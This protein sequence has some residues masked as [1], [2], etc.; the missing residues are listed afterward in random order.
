MPPQVLEAVLH[1]DSAKL[2]T[3]TGVD[4]GEQ[5]YVVVRLDA[6]LSRDTKAE[7]NARLQAQYAQAWGGA[8]T[9]AYLDALKIRHKAETRAPA[10]SEPA[11]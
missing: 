5:G 10:A 8:E 6:V 9:R 11:R 7:D 2:P 4:L 3:Y 1:L